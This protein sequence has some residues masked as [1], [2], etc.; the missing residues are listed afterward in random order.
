MARARSRVRRKPTATTSAKAGPP[1]GLLQRQ[2]FAQQSLGFVDRDFPIANRHVVL[3][4]QQRK[5]LRQ[6]HHI[7]IDPA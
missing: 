1:P 7:L 3:A 5:A 4:H 6:R 2:R